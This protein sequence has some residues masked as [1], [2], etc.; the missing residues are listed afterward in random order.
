[1]FKKLLRQLDPQFFWPYWVS[2]IHWK[3]FLPGKIAELKRM[4]CVIG[5]RFTMLDGVD[6][7]Y[8]HCWL[9]SI[10]NDVT[11]AP[12]VKILAHDASMYPYL[13]YARIG[14]VTL[15]NRVFI[16]AN[17]IVLPGVSIG[18]EAIVG[19]GS[20]VSR[21]I[22]ARSIAAGNPAKVLCGLDEF[23][24]RRKKEIAEGPYF[25]E[26]YTT[27]RNVSASGKRE[28]VDRLGS[29]FGYVK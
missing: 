20:V 12:G 15:G 26:S 5:D 9:V 28:M 10:G 24:A 25:D 16:G 27:P 23:L 4:G 22:P 13:G 17:S 8:N 6:I 1:M 19:A 29:G 11:L 3:Y 14:K 7:D 21:D 18:D 2:K